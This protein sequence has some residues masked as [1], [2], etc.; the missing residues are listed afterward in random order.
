MEQKISNYVRQHFMITKEG[1]INK[2]KEIINDIENG[3]G[4]KEKYSAAFYMRYLRILKMFYSRIQETTLFNELEDCWYYNCILYDTKM[5]LNLNHIVYLEINPNDEMERTISYDQ[6]FELV[7]VDVQLLSVQEFAELHSMSEAGVRQLI[8]RGRIPNAVKYGNTWRI[9]E[10][11]EMSNM[12]RLQHHYFI[13]DVVEG[14]PLGDDKITG[15]DHVI[16]KPDDSKKNFYLIEFENT[17]AHKESQIERLEAYY[18]AFSLLQKD[19]EKLESWLISNPLVK[20][21][22]SLITMIE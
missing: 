15:Y 20:T 5:V 3:R 10:L 8:R 12:R 9:P 13:D 19:K 17:K 14:I 22:S 1:V 7:S 21:P 11:S 6:R 16:I 4:L 18:K 2:L